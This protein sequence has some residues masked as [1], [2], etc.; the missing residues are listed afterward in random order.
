MKK[1]FDML[2]NCVL[3][4]EVKDEDLISLLGCL[5]AKVE[6]FERKYT[7]FSEGSPA[8]YIGI[9][10][11]GSVQ[12]EQN[13][14]Y[15]NRTILSN[16]QASE[17]FGESFACAKVSAI[18][19]SVIANETCEIMFIDINRILYSCSNSCAFHRQIIFN[20]MK[21]LANK[22]ILFHQK[23]EITSKRTTREK[24]M[25]FLLLQAKKNNSN[26]FDIPFD[27]QEHA[28]YLEVDRSGLSAVISKLR[29]EGII[30]N[31]KNHFVLL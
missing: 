27:R 15:G 21:T 23:I 26:S 7:I 6:I 11:S 24:L 5:N 8:N 22:N 2:R 3:F 4:D 13:D 30:K 18:P 17:I 28:D 1:Y 19:V 12:I 16:I 14:Y 9:V 29:N 25:A 10:L 20:L 31:K